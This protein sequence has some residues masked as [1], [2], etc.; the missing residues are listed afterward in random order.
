MNFNDIKLFVFDF[1]GVLTNNKFFLDE[2]GFESVQLSRSD[3]LA[4]S[5]LNKLNKKVLI[6]STEKNPIVTLR[7]N[8]LNVEVIQGCEDKLQSLEKYIKKNQ[9]NF[10]DIFYVGNDLNDFNVMKNCGYSACPN[11]SHY[12]IR[13][14]AH[15]TLSSNGGEG[16]I[17]EIIENLF[18][19]KIEKEI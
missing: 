2:N 13:Q 6:L 18:K 14:N 16:V 15:N 8:K 10:A 1:D 5:I 9:I 3:G 4:F 11:D 12:K 7:A 17:R 19:I